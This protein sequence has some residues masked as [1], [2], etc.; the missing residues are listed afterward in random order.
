MKRYEAS[1]L[2]ADLHEY[3]RRPSR[4][5]EQ[6][7][8][9]LG[10]V[11]GEQ[12]YAELKVKLSDVPE[13]HPLI[14]RLPQRQ[15]MDAAY[16]KASLA[17]VGKEIV[18]GKFGERCVLLE[19]WE[20]DSLVTLNAVLGWLRLRAVFLTVGPGKMWGYVGPLAPYLEDTLRLV[21]RRGRLTAAE[22]VKDRD[23]RTNAASNRLNRLHGLRLLKRESVNTQNGLMHVYHFW[24]WEG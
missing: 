13:G 3:L 20:P 11:K 10:R 21:A 18:K 14:L 7:N 19:G 9:F 4:P 16:V 2:T 23:L 6:G 15:V 24:Q 22:L 17:R 12:A 1:L 5:L 8:F